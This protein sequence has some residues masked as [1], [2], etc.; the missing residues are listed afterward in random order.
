MKLSKEELRLIIDCL[1][2][3]I[4]FGY[5]IFGKPSDGL[6]EVY[7]KLTGNDFNNEGE[8]F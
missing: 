7:K 2:F 8:L 3:T 4:K 5:T 1:H 6:L